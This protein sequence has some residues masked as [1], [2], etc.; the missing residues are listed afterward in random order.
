MVD[1]ADNKKFWKGLT[2][3]VPNLSYEI[4]GNQNISNHTQQNG[5]KQIEGLDLITYEKTSAK[6]SL[7]VLSLVSLQMLLLIMILSIFL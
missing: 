1:T 3:Q 6:L 4:M 7:Q 2:L 5:I